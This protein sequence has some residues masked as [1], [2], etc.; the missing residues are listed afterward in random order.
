MLPPGKKSGRTTN[1]SVEKA[2][3]APPRVSSAESRSA[4]RGSEPK[5]GAKTFSTSSADITPPPP[6]PITTLGWSRS[7]SGQLQPAKSGAANVRSQ[8][9]ELTSKALG[10]LGAASRR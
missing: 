9:T 4:A 1:E 10:A 3:R 8:P 6:C 7:G 5:A 2:S